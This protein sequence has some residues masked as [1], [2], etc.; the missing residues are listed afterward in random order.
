[1]IQDLLFI[2]DIIII[3]SGFVS[4]GII[5][6]WFI[7]ARKMAKYAEEHYDMYINSWVAFSYAI[8]KP[9]FYIPIANLAWLLHACLYVDEE[10]IIKQVCEDLSKDE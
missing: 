6:Y 5:A 2:L 10:E 4:C 1:M 9:R 7:I 3:T 8:M